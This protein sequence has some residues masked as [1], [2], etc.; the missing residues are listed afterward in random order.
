MPT[1]FPRDPLDRFLPPA[2]GVGYIPRRY[3]YILLAAFTFRSA[4]PRERRCSRRLPDNI[5]G[6]LGTLAA[7]SRKKSKKSS[8]LRSARII[9][10]RASRA[11]PQK[12]SSR[13][14]CRTR[15]LIAGG[16]DPGSALSISGASF[17]PNNA[18]TAIAT[19]RV[20][21]IP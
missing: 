11:A 12:A 18:G 4:P 17:R 10:T 6:L 15:G 2:F 8:R 7:A 13:T 14:R 16:R 20:P 3:S 9:A 1:Q 19:T 21:Y 5:S